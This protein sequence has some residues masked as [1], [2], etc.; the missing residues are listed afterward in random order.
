MKNLIEKYGMDKLLH[1]LGGAWVTSLFTPLG[2]YGVVVGVVMTAVVSVFKEMCLDQS[3]DKMDIVAAV[4][5]SG[6]SVIL[7]VFV[8]YVLA[9]MI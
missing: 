8:K 6:V 7:F 9:M 1:F 2:W 3:S 5:G 4:I